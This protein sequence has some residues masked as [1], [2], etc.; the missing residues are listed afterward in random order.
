[1][2]AVGGCSRAPDLETIAKFQ[3][4]QQAFD[5]AASPEDFLCAAA[6]YQE[7]LDAGLVSGAIFYNQGNAFMRAGQRG[8]AIACYRQ[9]SRYLPRNPYLDANL[10]FALG[11]SARPEST[12]S[13]LEQLLFWR[14]WIS[15]GGKFQLAAAAA[16]AALALGLLA[17]FVPGRRSLRGLAF[18]ALAITVLL[19]LSAA[20]DWRRYEWVEHGVTVRGDVTVRKGNAASYEPA[21]DQPLGEGAEFEVVERRGQWLLVRLA[22]GEEGW[23]EQ[24]AAVV[25]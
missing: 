18:A 10:R 1:M 19:S 11:A 13:V 20:Y 15:Y 2:L 6:L 5:G 14:D 16:A 4:A 25:F 3:A 7:I 9:A 22:G 8:R 21:F 17:L 24:Q 23:I 12:G